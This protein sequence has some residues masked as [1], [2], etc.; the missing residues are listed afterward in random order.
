MRWPDLW[1]VALI[2]HAMLSL[3]IGSGCTTGRGDWPYCNKPKVLIVDRQH[4]VYSRAFCRARLASAAS[5]KRKTAVP[6]EVRRLPV[7]RVQWIACR[8]PTDARS[9]RNHVTMRAMR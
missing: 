7:S 5:N 6:L 4:R 8:V 3:S 9:S 1:L 2:A